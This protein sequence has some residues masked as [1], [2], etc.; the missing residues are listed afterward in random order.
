MPGC[1]DA[2]HQYDQK[3]NNELGLD[4]IGYGL[5]KRKQLYKV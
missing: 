4:S 3:V 5:S 1:Q 2:G